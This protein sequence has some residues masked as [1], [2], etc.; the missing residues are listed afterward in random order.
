[1]DK[2]QVLVATMG[3]QD[4]SLAEKMNIRC[5]AVIA[6]QA[7][8]ERFE[9][10]HMPTGKLKMITTAT[11]GVGLNRN[12]AL[13]A[14]EG[15]LL[16]FADDDVVYRDD[17]PEKVIAA[18]R[19]NPN[20][21]LLIFG[22]DILRNGRV[23]ERRHLKNRRLHV[24]NAMRYGTYTI[25]ARRESILRGNISF[26]QC[27]GGG[28][29]Y[30]AGEDSL[31]LKE[32]FQKGLKIYSSDYVLGTCC[33]D[34]SSWFVGYNEKYFYDKGALVRHLFPRTCYFAAMYFAVRFKRKTDV[35]VAQRIRL[36]YKGV[37]GGRTL[38]PYRDET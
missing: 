1:M 37:R 24:W 25:A 33:K 7:D 9:E 30:S 15:E 17:M 38:R 36:V 27:F 2:L 20:A 29:I 10:T 35:P 13:L 12:I 22:I 8:R 11:R 4:F 5:G 34:T 23:T 28:C 18:F 26:H 21:D 32:C 16:M 3:Q 31:F 14:A 19:D 6:N